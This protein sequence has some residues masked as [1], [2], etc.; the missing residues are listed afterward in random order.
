MIEEMK[1]TKEKIKFKEFMKN[2]IKPIEENAILSLI[3]SV[4][5]AVLFIIIM[6][7]I[8]GNEMSAAFM[9]FNQMQLDIN[10]GI[11]KNP[12]DPLILFGPI[13][14]YFDDLIIFFILLTMIPLAFFFEK[15]KMRDRKIASEMPDFLKKLASTNETGMTLTQSINLISNSN[16]GS[17]SK[18]VKKIWKELQ[19]G[20][21]VNTALKKFAN[22]LNTSM[23]TRVITLIT[24]A[25]ESSGDI[26]DVLNV[27]ANDAKIGEQI[28][29]E[30]FDG[31]LIY[32]VV[33]FISFC[34]FIYCVYTLTSS[35]LPVMAKAAVSGTSSGSAAAGASFIQNFNPDDYYRLFFH[36]AII[37]G[38]FA[39]LL[40]GQ[41]GEGNWM[42]GL[43]YSII[44]VLIAYVMFAIFI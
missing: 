5:I 24:K 23:S 14:G 20:I 42:C 19:W 16:F 3:I 30:R 38:L 13:I 4:P 15:K 7:M 35:F 31:M 21:D 43:K 25:S 33:I 41:M 26:K 6:M 27:A 2:P 29:R 34:V 17:L 28:R 1:A 11:M 8:T 32:V 39:G 44:M 10:S 12:N 9:Q 37:Q 18:E 22:S 36:A 40:A